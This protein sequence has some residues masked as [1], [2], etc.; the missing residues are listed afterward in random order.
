MYVHPACTEDSSLGVGLTRTRRDGSGPCAISL[1]CSTTASRQYIP[2]ITC[3]RCYGSQCGSCGQLHVAIGEVQ[4]AA[5]HRITC[6]HG[7][8]VP[9]TGLTDAHFVPTNLVTL[10]TDVS[11]R[12]SE[13]SSS[14]Y[15]FS[16]AWFTGFAT[17]NWFTVWCRPLPLTVGLATSGGFTLQFI[18]I[19]TLI[20]C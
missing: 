15:G 16:V 9:A 10:V 13:N 17:V 20:R 11:H 8:R 2:D 14:I 18:A 7:S 6:G 4:T 1:A 19:I 12:R 5:I 3:V